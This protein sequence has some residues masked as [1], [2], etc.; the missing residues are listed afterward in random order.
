MNTAALDIEAFGDNVWDDK[1]EAIYYRYH[2]QRS[3]K[4]WQV[5]LCSVGTHYYA[6]DEY[7]YKIL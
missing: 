4:H 7:G 1:K 6:E 3:V 2:R 5:G